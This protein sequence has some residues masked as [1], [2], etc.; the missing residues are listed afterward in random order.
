L[1]YLVTEKCFPTFCVASQAEGA[2]QGS[3]FNT[4]GHDSQ[5]II[6]KGMG[7]GDHLTP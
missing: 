3:F 6:D 7:G 2:N 1:K 4:F 5:L